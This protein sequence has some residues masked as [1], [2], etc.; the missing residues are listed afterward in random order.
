[1]Q[2]ALFQNLRTGLFL[3][4]IATATACGPQNGDSQESVSGP[5]TPSETPAE[6]SN[7]NA[8]SASLLPAL[9]EK[10]KVF[11]QQSESI[12]ADRKAQLDKLA[13]Y[14]KTQQST[15]QASK[16]VFICTHNSRR[17]HLSQIWAKTA[18]EYYGIGSAIEAYSGGTEATAF[19]PR[20][21]AALERAGFTIEKPEGENPHYM[22]RFSEQTPA[23]E[24]FS[25][26]YDQAPNPSEGFA[27]V[28]TCS[29]ADKN[30]PSIPGA[31]VRVPIPYEDPK[32]ADGTPDEAKVYDERSAQIASE[33][34]YLMKRVK[35]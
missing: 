17:S 18:A 10:A 27:A 3:A 21:V 29:Q 7:S 16:L 30:C 2:I 31:A 8:S 20:A 19:N 34:F 6:N 9:L 5:A 25:K 26:V 13:L 33:M 28:M 15:G 24:C 35:A 4:T 23:L 11:E 1:M 12:P 14:I 22:V 32:A